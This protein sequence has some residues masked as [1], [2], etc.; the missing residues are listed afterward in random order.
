VTRRDQY[1]EKGDPIR[2]GLLMDNPPR[3]TD[4]AERIYDLIVEQYRASGRLERD[5][6]FVKVFPWGPPAG[7]IQNSVDAFH[8]LCDQNVIAVLGG[9]HAD[10]CI[11]LT[12][13]ADDRKVPLLNTGATTRAASAW[14]FSIS[15]GSIPHDVYTVASWLKKNGHTRIVM[16]WDRADHVG[17]NVVHF[18]NACARIGI[19]ILGDERFPQ[20]IVPRLDEIFTN[21]LR[22]FKELKPHALAHFGS[23]AMSYRWAEFVTKSGW[24]IPR[25]MNDAF[26]GA[27]NPDARA[28]YEGW[29]GTTMWDDDNQVNQRFFD[30]YVARYPD[31]PPLLSRELMAI[32]HDALT[33]LIEGIILAPILTPEGVRQGLEMV[34]MLPAAC[35]GRRTCIG[36]SP[37]AHRGLQGADVMV[38]RRAKDG[39]LIM[40]DRIELF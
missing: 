4:H 9:H 19:K 29:V 20:L 13:H 37:Y 26:H 27:N 8:S 32:F 2:I 24:N 6:E 28:G 10:D 36:F 34:Q 30:A 23:G 35:G 38:V 15:W 21:A 39:A 22:D 5:I 12:P 31:A 33:A 18:R 17:E 14:T 3:N 7:Y 25:I 40:E 16:T 11:A 1:K